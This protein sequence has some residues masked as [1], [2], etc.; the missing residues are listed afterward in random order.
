MMQHLQRVAF[1]AMGTTCS[2]AV[3]AR[4]CDAASAR[5]SL[6]VG[7]REVA[8]CEIALSR[9]DPQSDLS[10]LNRMA[11][12]WV[13]VDLRLIEALEAAVQARL[14]TAGRFDPTILPALVAAGYDRSYELLTEHERAPL[15]GW[16][17]GARIDL[18]LAGG[19]ARIERGAAVDL[20]GIGKGFAATRALAAMRVAW[21]GATGFIV[22]LGGDIAVWGAPPGGGTWKIDI[23]DPRTPGALAGILELASAGVATSGRD[24]RRFGPGR[25][26]HHLI[27]PATGVPAT[28]GPL[29]VTVVAANPTQAEAHAT[30]LSIADAEA[31]RA[32]IAEHPDLAALLIPHAGSPIVLGRLPLIHERTPVRIVFTPQSGRVPCH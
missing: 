32:H 12:E 22:D 28:S 23:A 8:C 5:A 1:G 4:T 13:A 10:L 11:G 24:T 27:D 18:D 19:R 16:H 26:L 9:F 17:A 29:A 2:V 6:K 20:G 3:S 7:R 30:A 14:Q 21:P 25:S 15:E 31:A